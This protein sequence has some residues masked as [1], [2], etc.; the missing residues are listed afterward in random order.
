[1]AKGKKKARRVAKSRA[2]AKRRQMGAV[3]SAPRRPVKRGLDWKRA[4][5]SGAALGGLGGAVAGAGAD[6][7]ISRFTDSEKT[8]KWGRWGKSAAG[9]LTQI[10]GVGMKSPAT[11]AAGGA[12]LA[13][14][15][16]VMSSEK[17]TEHRAKQAAEEANPGKPAEGWGETSGPGVSVVKRLMSRILDQA[18]DEGA[19]GDELAGLAEDLADELMPGVAGQGTTSYSAMMG[20]FERDGL[21]GALAELEGTALD[22]S[23]GALESG[24]AMGRY[25][26]RDRK[27][28]DERKRQRQQRKADKRGGGQ[29]QLSAPRLQVNPATQRAI[30]EAL[31]RR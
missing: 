25:K 1:M 6:Y 12:L 18:S 19:D 7:A 27:S 16:S 10:L 2:P 17:G 24:V 9:L 13:G 4:G 21:A 31:N 8:R 23:T 3:A 5:S 14:S 26:R 15:L 22:V 29:R 28:R 30:D 11:A 20:A